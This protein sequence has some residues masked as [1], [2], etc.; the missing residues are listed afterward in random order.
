MLKGGNNFKYSGKA[1]HDYK[2]RL[3]MDLAL[4]AAT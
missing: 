4:L 3:K 2:P 1:P